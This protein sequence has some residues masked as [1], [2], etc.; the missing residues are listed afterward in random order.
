[1]SLLFR[2]VT[3]HAQQWP[4]STALQGAESALTYAQ[5][6]QQLQLGGHELHKA[7]IKALGLL[8]DNG[9]AWA[10]AD[11]S[12]LFA[13]ILVVPLPP[14]FSPQQLQHAIRDSGLDAILTDQPERVEKLLG[15]QIHRVDSAAFGG[16]HMLKLD[17]PSAANIPARSAKITYTSGTTGQ[18]KGVCLSREA[19]ESVA[20]SLCNASQASPQDRH[21]CLLPLSTLLENIG[22]IYVPLL[23]GACSTVLPLHQVGLQGAAAL[24]VGQMLKS[25]HES[26][27]S[28]AIMVPQMLHAVVAALSMGAAKPAQLRFI[29]VGGAPVSLRLLISAQRLGLPVFEGYGLSECASVVA[30]NAPGAN[31]PG[32]VGK[33]LPHVKLKFAGLS[34]GNLAS[35]MMT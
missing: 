13:N 24:D 5:L 22:G 25:L 29:A 17:A 33:P 2:A 21:L 30:V 11:L 27:A 4:D 15:D 7:G 18:P 14:F 10:V 35:S 31:K 3:H 1:M 9:L 20:Q 23:A 28:S 12:A 16:L 26:R 8:A 6:A 32:S 34:W 19:M